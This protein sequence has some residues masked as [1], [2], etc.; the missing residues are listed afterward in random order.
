[1]VT[2]LNP[3]GRNVR[4]TSDSRARLALTTVG[5]ETVRVVDVSERGSL[6]AGVFHRGNNGSACLWIAAV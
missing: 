6:E 4:F 1:M 2:T 3:Q 5:T